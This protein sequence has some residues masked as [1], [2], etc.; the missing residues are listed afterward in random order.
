MSAKWSRP[1]SRPSSGCSFSIPGDA[2]ACPPAISHRSSAS[3]N[4]R[5]TPGRSGSR[6]KGPAGLLDRVRG[7][8]P[9]SRLP[10]VTRRTILMLKEA[11]PDWG[12]QRISDMLVRGPA[13][14][15]SPGA[16]ARVLHEAGYAAEETPTRPHEPKVIHFERARSQP[17]LA[18]RPLHLRAQTPEPARLSRGLPRRSQPL[19]RWLRPARQPVD[20]PGARSLAGGHRQL[21][22]ARGGAD[23]QRHAVRHLAGQ[24]RVRQGLRETRRAPDR[25]VA[26]PSANA[27]QDRTVLGLRCGAS[28]SR[29]R[30][31]STSATPGNA[32][33]CSSTV[34]ISSGRIRAS[35]G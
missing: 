33:A 35:K 7:P 11:H 32:S 14:P 31:S 29:P 15:A 24:K 18:N 6:P 3:P 2:A 19:H 9:G 26:A 12:C 8:A 4:T 21:R 25:R 23:R 13:L 17:T 20:G 10:E 34:T 22:R 28:A 27:R 1:T 16:V 5:S 30:S